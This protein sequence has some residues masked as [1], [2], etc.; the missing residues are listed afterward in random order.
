MAQSPC[1]GLQWVVH[2]DFPVLKNKVKRG[3]TT[4]ESQMRKKPTV[5]RSSTSKPG[6]D[7]SLR[8]CHNVPPWELFLYARSF[9][10]AAKAL[11]ATFLPEANSLSDFDAYPV[12]FMYRH[13]LELHLKA[14][15]LG[16]GANFL[17]TK[18]DPISI[19]NS[20]SISWLAQFVCQ[21]ITAVKWEEEFRCEG[22]NTLADFKAFI[23]DVSSVDPGLYTFRWPINPREQSAV[24]EFGQKMDAVIGLLESTADALAAEWDMRSEVGEI[25]DDLAGGGFEPTVQ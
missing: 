15:V 9:H 8:K 16:E 24:H 6:L 14:F 22:I 19:R 21:I 13:A 18:P 20:H 23:D 10:L 17:E 25:E 5:S 3:Y 12:I 1:H 7:N 11:A 4:V 2:S